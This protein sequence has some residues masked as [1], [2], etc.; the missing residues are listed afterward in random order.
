MQKITMKNKTITLKIATD[1]T[2]YGNSS[3]QQI[4]TLAIAM[5][6]SDYNETEEY[7]YDYF[8][9]VEHDAKKEWLSSDAENYFKKTLTPDQARHFADNLS[10]YNQALQEYKDTVFDDV[11]A[12]D[13]DTKSEHADAMKACADEMEKWLSSA[14]DDN[15][16]EWLHGDYR[17]NFD[18][19]IPLA[20]KMYRDYGIEIEYNNKADEI[21]ATLSDDTIALLIEDGNIEKKSKKAVKDWLECDIEYTAESKH[22]DEMRKAETRRAEYQKTREYKEKRRIENEKKK[23]DELLALVK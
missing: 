6:G 14:Q 12:G 20:N 7:N 3:D 1:Y 8:S 15:Y 23:R 19:I 2:K 5:T 4:D 11:R 22:A 17:G 13:W 21:T 18:G 16:K 9:E 10:E